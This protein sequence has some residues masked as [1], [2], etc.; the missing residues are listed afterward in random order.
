MHLSR[1]MA[2]VAILLISIPML[3]RQATQSK[4]SQTIQPA[5]QDTQAVNVLNQALSFAGGATAISGVTDYT[6]TGTVTYHWDKDVQGNVTLQGL[7]PDE[8]RLDANLPNGTRS[9]AIQEGQTAIKSEQ[10]VLT[11]IPPQLKVIPSSDAY[12]YEAPLFPTSIAFPYLQLTPVLGNPRYSISYKGTVQLA[13]H[14]AH[15]VLVQFYPNG[16]G[17]PDSMSEY[18]TREFFIDTSSLQVLLIQESVPKHV[19][20]QVRYSSYTTVNGMLVPFSI[21][22]EVGGQPTWAIQLSKITFNTG[23]QDSEFLIQ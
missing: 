5:P 14:S 6:A 10:G 8:F 12:P 16:Q 18:R 7:G 17:K 2:V 13:G 3:A 21:T 19:I 1:P 4:I 15:D 20:R 9:W 23:L 22:E 11:H